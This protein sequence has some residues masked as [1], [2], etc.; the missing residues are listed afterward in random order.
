MRIARWLMLLAAAGAVQAQT[1]TP[2][3][4]SGN[5]MLTGTYYFRQVYYVIGDTS[6]DL[7]EAVS[8]YGNVSFDGNGNYSITTASNA[9]IYDS[10][11]EPGVFTGSGTYSIAASGYGFMT[12]PYATGDVVYGT[13]S[14]SGIFI[15]SSTDNS[16]GYNDMLIAA[17]LA[18]PV[19]TLSS[20]N[21][22]WTAADFDFSSGQP[23]SALT[24]VFN[25]SPDGAGNL[26]A[27]PITGYAGGSAQI[28][29]QT[30]SG[31]KY[32]FSN[33]AAVATFPVNGELLSGQKYFYFS[34]DGNFMFGGSPYSSNTPFDFIVAVKNTGT[35]TLSGLY[36]QAGFDNY[37]G[38]LDSYF[39]SFN[40]LKG[41]A[42]Q[43]YLGHQRIND[44]GGQ[45]RLRLHFR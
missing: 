28:Y 30:S 19:P 44:F 40:V 1:T 31:L 4:T 21:G 10:S 13:V 14:A 16:Y 24:M 23:G 3:D 2:W 18:S 22:S 5:S 33:G 11:S 20:F 38:D 43:T 27:G 29:T 37:D 26:N 34:K 39:G 42:P 7:S 12:S 6:G 36:Y 32:T 9:V 17:P 15:G 45:Q 25:M 35:P 41:A 8:I